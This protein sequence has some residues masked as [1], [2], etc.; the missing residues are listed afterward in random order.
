MKLTPEIIESMAKE[1]NALLI[2]KS[3]KVKVR[4]KTA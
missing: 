2:E 3:K 4:N 1:Q